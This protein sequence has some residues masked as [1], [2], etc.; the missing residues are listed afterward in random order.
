MDKRLVFGV[1]VFYR[2]DIKNILRLIYED[3]TVLEPW[4]YR[5]IGKVVTRPRD[6]YRWDLGTPKSLVGIR[7]PQVRPGTQNS[8]IFKW[9]PGFMTPKTKLKKKWNFWFLNFKFSNFELVHKLILKNSNIH[10]IRQLKP[11]FQI[12]KFENQKS[13][14][15][16]FFSKSIWKKLRKFIQFSNFRNF[17]KLP[18]LKV[19]PI[20]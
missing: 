15:F 13:T 18:N 19:K 10:I 8:K 12:S 7:D 17:A 1:L 2:V 5:Q 20:D 9:N 6:V 4:K 14:I 11:P 3:V 16:S